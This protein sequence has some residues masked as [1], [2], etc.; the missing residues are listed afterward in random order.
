M[1]AAKD[2]RL[3]LVPDDAAAADLESLQRAAQVLADRHTDLAYQAQHARAAAHEPVNAR[4]RA[5]LISKLA[6]RLSKPNADVR[7]LLDEFGTVMFMV[8]HMDGASEARPGLADAA[9]AAIVHI[10]DLEQ[11]IREEMDVR[12]H[13][14]AA[15]SGAAR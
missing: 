4:E 9:L 13:P 7:A 14:V 3:H 10:E 12:I 15:E 8:G 6:H 5:A 1:T 2:R 11:K